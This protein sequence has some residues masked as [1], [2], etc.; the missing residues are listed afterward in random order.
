MEVSQTKDAV[1]L[2]QQKFTKELLRDCGF[3]I[4]H[5]AATPLPL[6]CKLLPD[7]GPLLD[8]PT[9]YRIL[10]GKLNFLTNTRP[11]LSF[12]VQTLSQ[13][14][15]A[16]RASHLQALLHTLA[17][18]SGTIS[19]GILLQ[20]ADKLILQAFSDS[21]WAA[22]SFSRRSVTGYILM[23]GSSPISWK[24]KKQGTVSRSSSEAEYRAVA[25]AA[26]EVVWLV[27]LLEDL[28]TTNLTPVKLTCDNQSALHIARN[29]AFHE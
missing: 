11:D 29:P 9:I 13:F 15:Q 8:D 21:D 22:C 6:N 28:G 1:L 16:P 25:Q 20:G 3:S 4:K 26:S 18:I 7:E 19:K 12:S 27:R 10:V 24:S 2:S 5:H 14:L 23:L 17:Y